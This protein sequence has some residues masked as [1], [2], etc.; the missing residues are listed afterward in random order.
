MHLGEEEGC[1]TLD[2]YVPL[3]CMSPSAK[4]AVMVWIY[5]GAW[6]LGDKDEF[7]LYDAYNLA[8]EYEVIVV[9]M[10]YRLDVLGWLALLA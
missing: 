10:N 6:V 1:L 4:C 2:V 8:N 5:G 3:K 7:G 9:A